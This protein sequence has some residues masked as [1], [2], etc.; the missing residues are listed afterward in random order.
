MIVTGRFFLVVALLGTID[1]TVL[2]WRDEEVVDLEFVVELGARI[3]NPEAVPQESKLTAASWQTAKLKRDSNY[4]ES[5]YIS[6]LYKGLK[7]G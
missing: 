1:Y 6:Y 3:R 7:P 2:C 4:V 5:I